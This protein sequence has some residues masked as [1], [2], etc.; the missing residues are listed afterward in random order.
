MRQLQNHAVLAVGG[1][2]INDAFY[3]PTVLLNPDI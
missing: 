3:E 1:K 2:R